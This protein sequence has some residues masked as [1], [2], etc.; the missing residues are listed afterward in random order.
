MHGSLCA[1]QEVSEDASH[2]LNLAAVVF[3]LRI[4]EL[5]LVHD[6]CLP[7]DSDEVIHVVWIAR[8]DEQNQKAQVKGW[9]LKDLDKLDRLDQ[10]RFL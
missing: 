9:E 6:R 1:N 5:N 10:V 4:E 7:V 8:V 3:A 2:S